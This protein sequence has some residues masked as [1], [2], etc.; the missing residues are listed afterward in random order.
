M[1]VVHKYGGTSVATIEKIQAVAGRVAEV[2]RSGEDIAVVASAMG[3]TTDKLIQMAYSLNDA[4]SRRELDSLLSTGEQTTVTLLAMALE[5]LGVP[6]VSFTGF[7]AGIKTDSSHSHATI[8]EIDSRRIEKTIADGKVPVIAG[9]Q[10][11]DPE[12]DIATLGRGGSDTTAVAVAAKLGWDCE[13]YTDVDGVYT[14][15]PRRC[16][17]ARKLDV[18]TADEMIELSAMGAGVLETKSVEIAKRY[19][20]KL[21]L[22]R[23]LEKDKSKGTYVVSRPF[24]GSVVTGMGIMDDCAM[25]QARCPFGDGSVGRVFG[26]LSEL[27]IDADMVYQQLLDEGDVILSFGCKGEDATRLEHALEDDPEQY[28]FAIKHRLARISLVGVGLG[29]RSGVAEKMI[30]LL[31]ENNIEH[32]Q[33]STSEITVS[34]V[35]DQNDLQR[36]CGLLAAAFDLC[37]KQEGDR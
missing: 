35:I 7:Q 17:D 2:R 10:G 34:A 8:M 16:P 24:N 5:A 9:F 13:I 6:A 15:D 27:D 31:F 32:Y 30:G 26:H 29:V 4:P 37:E 25:I 19:G 18:I 14:V 28:G 20:V 22:G 33:I 23:S 3:K 12:G 1:G 11:I 36:A 21:Y